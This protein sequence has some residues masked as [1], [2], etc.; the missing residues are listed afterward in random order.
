ME[1]RTKT[2]H[3]M[4]LING[5]AKIANDPILESAGPDVFIGVGGHKDRRNRVS[6]IDEASVELESGHRGHMD[7]GDQAG[8]F[9][10]VRGSEEIGS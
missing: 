2:L 5:L 8:G 3:E 7:V 6:R 10:K 4:L 1:S 9:D